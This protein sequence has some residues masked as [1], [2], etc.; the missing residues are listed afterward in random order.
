VITFSIITNGANPPLLHREIESIEGACPPGSYEIIVVGE[1]PVGLPDTVKKIWDPQSARGGKICT[2]RNRGVAAAEGD[3]IVAVDDDF[4]FPENFYEELSIPGREW[5]VMVTRIINPDG[6]RFWDWSTLG[7]PKG[8][9][10]LPY[11]QGDPHLYLTGGFI[12]MKSHVAKS[13][14]WPEERGFYEEEDVYFSRDLLSRG[15]KIAFNMKIV[16]THNDRRYTAIKGPR[17][18]FVYRRENL[19]R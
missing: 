11:G 4:I 7:G 10:L 15:Y 17:G 1:P 5:D 12:I 19:Q 13:V 2:L 14:P 9:V 8:H 18:T 16:M 6:T 3:I